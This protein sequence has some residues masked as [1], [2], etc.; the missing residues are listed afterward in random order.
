MLENESFKEKKNER[1]HIHISQS[2]L[3]NFIPD[4]SEFAVKVRRRSL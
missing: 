3:D 2:K 4:G 1:L